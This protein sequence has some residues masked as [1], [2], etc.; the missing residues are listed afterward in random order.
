[1][2]VSQN[3]CMWSEILLKSIK[4]KKHQLDVHVYVHIQIVK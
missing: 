3:N 1:M 4:I 2:L